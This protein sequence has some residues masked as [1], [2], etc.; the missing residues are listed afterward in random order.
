MYC[1]K[2]YY[3]KNY[4]KVFALFQRILLRKKIEMGHEIVIQNFIHCIYHN[5]DWVVG[6]VQGVATIANLLKENVSKF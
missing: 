1:Y 6:I 2:K 5:F 4:V 3:L